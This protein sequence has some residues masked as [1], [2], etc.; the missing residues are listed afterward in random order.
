M[1]WKMGDSVLSIGSLCVH[2]PV[3]AVSA[4]QCDVWL[5]ECKH[6]TGKGPGE[7]FST[8]S[9]RKSQCILIGP[10]RSP[11]SVT[12]C[13]GMTYLGQELS[14]CPGGRNGEGDQTGQAS[15]SDFSELCS[16]G[17]FWRMGQ[18]ESGPHVAKVGTGEIGLY[19]ESAP[20]RGFF[21]REMGR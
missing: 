10:H 19:L 16:M 5:V 14:L 3:S 21:L 4:W 7:Q 6:G 18:G 15:S 1:P 9:F 20:P 12:G 2:S 8:H 17:C 11:E 13:K